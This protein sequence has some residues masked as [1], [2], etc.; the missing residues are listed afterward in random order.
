MFNTFKNITG[1]VPLES[2]SLPLNLFA[3]LPFKK[4]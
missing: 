4:Q 2:S 1:I 3:E